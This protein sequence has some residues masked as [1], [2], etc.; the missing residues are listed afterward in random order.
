MTTTIEYLDALPGTGKTNKIIDWMRNNPNKKF[1]YISPMLDEVENRIPNA[2]ADS[3][4]FDF[5]REE[6]TKSA[7]FLRMLEAGMNISTTHKLFLSSKDD[8]WEVLKRQGYD[9][10]IDEEVNMFDPFN[11]K[12]GVIDNLLG[13]DVIKIN[14]QLHGQVNLLK[15]ARETD[16]SVGK[17]LDLAQRNALFVSKRSNNILVTQLPIELLKAAKR[18]IVLTYM[19]EG[20]ILHKFTQLHGLSCRPFA[21]INLEKENSKAKQKIKEL[22]TIG[23]T[24]SLEALQNKRGFLS[25]NWYDTAPKS[26]RDSLRVALRSIFRKHKGNKKE[27]MLTCPLENLERGPKHVGD[28][29]YVIP[30][31]KGKTDADINWLSCSARATNKWKDRSIMIH[32]LDRYP[33]LA[34]SSYLQDYGYPV[35]QD[36]FALSEMIQW[37][38]RG[39]IRDGKE[40]TVYVLSARMRGL[41]EDW[42]N[43]EGKE[44]DLGV[45]EAA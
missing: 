27:I 34:V 12:K 1:I 19:F 36:Q 39:C 41:L 25:F 14:D 35:D 7:D 30:K 38:W 21:E 4:G 42:L 26:E 11:C 24:P 18:T 37:L 20:S 16:D 45:L 28:G 31:D 44:A 13:W 9:V 40:M 17:L 3:I 5:P 32:A 23:T 8:H 33:N 10:I 2:L 6:P 29:Q 15:E 43:D 22:L